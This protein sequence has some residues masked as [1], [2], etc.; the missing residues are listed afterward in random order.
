MGNTYCDSISNK[1]SFG[2]I[3]N[4]LLKTVN[5]K[6]LN[7]SKQKNSILYNLT[8]DYYEIKNQKS[9]QVYQ[10]SKTSKNIIN[11][12]PLEKLKKIY[13]NWFKILYNIKESNLTEI[14]LN[15]FKAQNFSLENYLKSNLKKIYSSNK[16][17]FDKI[18]T[19]GVPSHLRFD[20]W[21]TILGN[22]NFNVDDEQKEFNKLI[23]QNLKKEDLKQ[24]QKDINRTFIDEKDHTD[25]N[26]N[27]LKE[28]LIA[29]VNMEENKNYC[30]GMN[31]IVGFLLKLTDFSKIK[32]F[33]LLKN[34]F[35]KINGFFS[36]KSPLLNHYLKLFKNLFQKTLPKLFSHF[37]KNDVTNE[38]WISKWF[39]TIFTISL[40]F[41]ELCH[42][43]DVLLIYDFDFII[44]FSL[45]IL[46]FVEKNLLK[47]NDSFDI[48]G[49]LENTLN[50][51]KT[52]LVNVYNQNFLIINNTIILN[53]I[54][55]K[56]INIKKNLNEP[57]PERRHSMKINE[58]NS[59]F[60]NDATMEKIMKKDLSFPSQSTTDDLSSDN[61]NQN[62]RIIKNRILQKRK[63]SFCA[64][65]KESKNKYLNNGLKSA[66]SC[67]NIYKNDDINY[68][69]IQIFNNNFNNNTNII[70]NQLFSNQI[71]N[72]NMTK[73]CGYNKTNYQPT[74]FTN[75]DYLNKNLNNYLNN[76]KLI[77]CPS[78]NNLPY[79]LY[80]T[81]NNQTNPI[82]CNLRRAS[83]SPSY[84]CAFNNFN[85]G[86]FNKERIPY[87]NNKT[88]LLNRYRKISD[89]GNE[90]CRGF[91][92][93]DEGEIKRIE[94][95]I[96]RNVGLIRK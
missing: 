91:N 35:P 42:L 24:I 4:I 69:T 86:Y 89:E 19:E 75:C 72:N 63:N 87:A 53:D 26:I 8:R 83:F 3:D 10:I 66:N 50:P 21:T 18:V 49:F 68:K 61:N 9:P 48:A 13:L 11:Y 46:E 5:Q 73:F 82:S 14:D 32:T 40:P 84:N 25:Q 78:Q 22:N 28:L 15:K 56:A 34:I 55:L 16:I 85:Y 27:S 74:S 65:N 58:K 57:N 76:K 54:I 88:N 79:N 41:N 30:Q 60:S 2:T 95:P 45:S 52:N 59:S 71:F 70:D 77:P 36:R 94:I 51:D 43:W 7:E 12:I 93:L 67:Q 20:I 47:L 44:P 38:L 33:Y 29:L 64:N 39:Q 17:T 31:F 81:K 62:K 6:E 37:Q 96:F 92:E 90:F 23:N 1:F 80:Y